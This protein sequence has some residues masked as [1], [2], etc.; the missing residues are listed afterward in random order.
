MGQCEHRDPVHRE[1]LVLYCV[2][3]QE[4]TT[5]PSRELRIAE[6]VPPQGGCLEKPFVFRCSMVIPPGY[7]PGLARSCDFPGEL[8]SRLGRVAPRRVTWIFKDRRE[9]ILGSPGTAKGIVCTAH[10]PLLFQ[11][12]DVGNSSAREIGRADSTEVLKGSESGFGV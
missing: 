7:Y 2:A 11:D 4:A 9:E 3:V 8:S 6:G 5:L 12:S 10:H 1:L